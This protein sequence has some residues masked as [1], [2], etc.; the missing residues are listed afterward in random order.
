[1][2]LGDIK[3]E[4]L[5]IM[6]VNTF[7]N[8]S[9]MDIDGLK[10]DSTYSGYLYAMIGAINRAFDRFYIKEAVE[11]PIQAISVETPE[12][13]DMRT[14]GLNDVLARMIPLFIVG[15]IFAMEE[16][17][18]SANNRN[19]FE[20]SLEEYLDAKRTRQTQVESIY[21]VGI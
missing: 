12:E 18:I 4:A 5:K 7:M 17:G 6:N 3:A 14:Y 16:P 1:M 8:I 11:E 19:L 20:A 2:F 21:R 13:T 9:Y 15:D 10:A